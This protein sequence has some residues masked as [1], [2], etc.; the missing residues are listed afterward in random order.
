MRLAD[1]VALVTGSGSGIGRAIAERFAREGARVIVNDLHRDRAEET[2][3]RIA[4]AGG[5]ALAIQAD[6]T[7]SAAVQAMV[8]QGIAA[9]GQIDILVN[10]AGAS[11]GDDILTFDEATWDWNLAV[12]LK[13]A[14]LCSRA[15]LPRMIER[16]SGA[17][18][19]ISSVNGIAGLGEEAYSAAKAGMNVLTKNMAVKYG[20]F[21]IRVN[22]I[23]PGT[24]RTPI[25]GPRLEKDP[26]IFEKLAK[27]YPLGR[28]GEPEDIA[29][30]ALFL[31]SD[32]ASWITGT[33]LIVDGGLLAGSYRMTLELEGKSEE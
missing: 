7:Q 13:S 25:W 18:V 10:N 9:F 21:G 19:N 12:V 2:V 1:K 30:A 8:E 33:V 27:W 5:E 23:C 6:V 17:I 24:I 22:V 32:E 28:V 29:N 14:Y 20:R 15:V 11:Q 26:L 3:Q 4:A 16:R 31:A